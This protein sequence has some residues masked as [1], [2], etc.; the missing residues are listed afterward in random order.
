MLA[1]LI[2]HLA[3]TT[4]FLVRCWREFHC[5]SVMEFKKS[6][7][8]T[9]TVEGRDN[10]D[11][12]GARSGEKIPVHIA[13]RF[14]LELHIPGGVGM[15]QDNVV[16][17]GINLGLATSTTPDRPYHTA[18]RTSPT[19]W[20]SSMFSYACEFLL[21]SAGNFKATPKVIALKATETHPL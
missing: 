3:S 15:G 21:R 7:S 11:H 12:A 5:Q 2:F 9:G 8:P 6:I 20:C 17:P 14:G 18:P 4:V 16:P 19:N 10:D 13:G 1:A